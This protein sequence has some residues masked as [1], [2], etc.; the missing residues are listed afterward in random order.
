MRYIRGMLITSWLGVILGATLS[1]SLVWAVPGER[2]TVGSEFALVRE[3]PH[4]AA[5]VVARILEQQP[6][7]EIARQQNWLQVG[8]IGKGITGWIH[9]SFLAAMEDAQERPQPLIPPMRRFRPAFDTF[10]FMQRARDGGP[11][12]TL[13]RHPDDGVLLV[14][15][16]LIWWSSSPTR[17][18]SDLES[19][20]QMWKVAND[21]LPVIVLIDDPDGRRQMKRADERAPARH[22]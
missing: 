4:G 7:I 5:P 16:S 13:L 9:L 11:P 14:S 12:F 15:A 3:Q 18:R 10:N 1:S 21:Q 22:P 8:V 17:Q 20:Y 19:L 2:H 6:V